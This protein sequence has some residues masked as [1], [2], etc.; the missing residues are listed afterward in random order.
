MP[1]TASQCRSRRWQ[2][3]PFWNIPSWDFTL[4]RVTRSAFSRKYQHLRKVLAEARLAAG[5]TQV[6]LARQLGRPQSF[7]S[8]F[9]RGERRLDV[10]EF[11]EIT[12]ALKLQPTRVLVEIERI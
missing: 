4:L 3:I 7:V 10:V 9:E 11:L 12:R 8:K 2:V 1:E 6:E 5:V